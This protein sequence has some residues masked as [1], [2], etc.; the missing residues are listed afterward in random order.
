M[1]VAI[2][3]IFD[4]IFYFQK[5]ANLLFI[6]YNIYSMVVVCIFFVLAIGLDLLSMVFEI[7]TN[8]STFD[9]V[10]LLLMLW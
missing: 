6:Y 5:N 10:I 7:V 9:L 1:S 3:T 8:K 4:T 2:V